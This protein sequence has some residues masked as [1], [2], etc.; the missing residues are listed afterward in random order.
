MNNLASILILLQMGIDGNLRVFENKLIM[1]IQKILEQLHLPERE[2]K[3]YIAL[4]KQG[5]TSVG[6]IVTRTKLHRQ[7]VYQ[8][9]EKLKDLRMASVVIKNGRQH[10]HATDPSILLEQVQNQQ[11][12]AQQAVKELEAIRKK[13]K[14][15]LHVEILYGAK[16]L[17][18]NLVA[19][20]KVAGKTDKIIRVMG[21]AGD[22]LYGILGNEYKSYH[23]LTQKL[24]VK[25][26]IIVPKGYKENPDDEFHQEK[27]NE[28]RVWPSGLT[29]PTF[30]R[31]TQ[32]MVSIEVYGAEPLI[33][34][35]KNKTI[36]QSY[37]ESFDSL[38]K[39]AK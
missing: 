39:Q 31:I 16:G 8:S 27:G 15:D 26:H 17:L 11:V 24:K 33:I 13:A 22:V 19:H 3:V 37:I 14:D 9:L 32:E 23:D 4:L 21:G 20:T 36:A 12:I 35:I 2:A 18:S 34:Q 7:M 10:W 38:W 5:L 6:P 25:K 29:S 28:M 30:N 1:Q